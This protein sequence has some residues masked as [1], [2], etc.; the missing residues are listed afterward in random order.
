LADL[1][2]LSV[3][4]TVRVSGTEE[5]FIVRGIVATENEANINDLLAAF[6]GFAYIPADS[7]PLLQQNPQPNRISIVLPEGSDI[8]AEALGLR[9]IVRGGLITSTD[10]LLERNA[11]IADILGDLILVM[12]LGALLIGGVG[13]IN[14]MLVMMRRRTT[15]IAT[16]KTFGVKGRQVAL[17]FFAEAAL[18]GFI[19]SLVG[20]G[21]GLLLSGAVNSYGE[22]FLQQRLTW[23]FHPEAVWYGL[24][25]GMVVSVVFGVI[26]VLLAV[27]VRPATILR[28]NESQATGLGCL[29]TIGVLLLVVLVIGFIAGQILGIVWVGIAGVAATLIVLGVLTGILWL[30][31]WLVGKLP[32]FGIVDLRLALRN[33]TTNRLRTATTLLALSAGMFALS[34]IT[35][36]GLGAREILRFQ[37]TESMGGNVLVLP[38]ESVLL[39]QAMVQARVE[40][41]VDDIEGV[42]SMNSLAFYELDIVAVNGE[43]PH[44]NLPFGMTEEDFGEFMDEDDG[45]GAFSISATVR[46]FDSTANAPAIVAG[47]DLTPEDIGQPVIVLTNDKL[48]TGPNGLGITVGSILTLRT[49]NATTDFEVVGL[50]GDFTTLNFSAGQASFPPESITA[51]PNF[52]LYTLLVAPENMN[53]VLLELST[54]PLLFALDI[55]FIDGLMKRLIDQFSAIPTL[56]GLLSL[57]AAAVIMANTVSLATLERRRQIG[58]L[59][60]IGLKGRR[61]LLVMLLENTVIGLLG[62]LLGIGVSSIG[63]SLLTSTGIG[64]AIPIPTDA[65]PIAIGL[66]VA[67]L[68]IAWVATFLSARVAISE[69]VLN[70][71]RYE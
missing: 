55:T 32:S 30:I 62:G 47:R 42:E 36:F 16:L 29:Q 70:V 10:Y 5:P 52:Q 46:D 26:P 71:L 49:R 13:I 69:R 22:A 12:G 23:R 43:A 2:A 18:L 44:F 66:I 64:E 61:V 11:E 24:G 48:L 50:R 39:P 51:G 58:I 40:G 41:F 37:L 31:V 35:F 45:G 17:L 28:P 14:T 56:V 63:V 19:G 59:K 4:D 38:L 57:L 8:G 9:G 68:L 34:S 6:F 15:E 21:A 1:Q 65:T 7:A 67:A 33:L 27:K 3:G 60:A 53:E 25:L 54:V 20:I